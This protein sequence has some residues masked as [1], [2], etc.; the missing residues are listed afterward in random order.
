[1]ANRLIAHLAHLEV[2]TPMPDES[3][4]FFT[5]VLGLEETEREGQSVYLRAW[6]EWGH[7]SLMLTEAPQPGLGH[8]AWRVESP[9]DL[10]IAVTRVEERDAG[11]GWLDGSLGHGP[12]FRYRSPGGHLHELFWEE[13]RYVPPPGME[14][15]YPDRPQRYVPRGVAP[16]HIDHVTVMAR[17]PLG[18]AR[19]FRDT[20][21]YR[22]TGYIAPDDEADVALFAMVSTNEKAHDLGLI[23][24]QSSIPGRLH[25]FAW[26]VETR[27]ELLRAADILLNADVAVEF[28]PGRHGMGEQDYLYVREPGGLRVEVNTGGY[29]LYVPDWETK[30]WLLPEGPTVFYKNLE[31]PESLFEAFP[32]VDAAHELETA[33]QWSPATAR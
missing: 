7:H 17:D 26:W 25:H 11:E 14:S 16:R 18:D 24:D 33:R 12:A 28:G 21:A 30:R 27:D 15:P 20:L 4:H 19:W 9:E 2:F 13:Q 23:V 6:G 5:Q 1:M 31:V 32:P 3:L 10:D 22:F 8:I 29:R